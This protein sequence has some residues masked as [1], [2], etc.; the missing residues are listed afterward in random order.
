M[1]N[2]IRTTIR[3]S[4]WLSWQMLYWRAHVKHRSHSCSRLLGTLETRPVHRW[5]LTCNFPLLP[6][7]RGRIAET[8]ILFLE[9]SWKRSNSICLRFPV[10]FCQR[11][12]GF[13]G[14]DKPEALQVKENC[15][16]WLNLGITGS[17]TT[18]PTAAVSTLL[19]CV[20]VCVCLSTAC[21]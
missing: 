16:C 13:M 14:Q 20:C 12:K 6:F 21:K 4:Q 3:V 8:M 7:R 19:L 15:V 18:E 11:T 2:K 10:K 5:F 17:K 1:E 9:A